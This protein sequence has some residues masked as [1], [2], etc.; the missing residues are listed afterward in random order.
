MT[1][2]D[3]RETYPYFCRVAA[4][5]EQASPLFMGKNLERLRAAKPDYAFA[6]KLC[7]DAFDLCSSSEE[8]WLRAA[9]TLV[10]FSMEF[11]H[12]QRQ[13][14]ETGR[15]LYSTF[16]EVEQH[17]YNDPARALSGPPYLWAMYFTQAFWI[18]HAKVWQFFLRDFASAPGR[19][20]VVLEVPSGNGLF[21]THF[22]RSNPRWRGVGVD[23]SDGSI[24]F[25]RRMTALN[26]L[27]EVVDVRKQDFFHLDESQRFERIICGEFLEHVED[28]PSVLRK[29]R[30]LLTKNGRLFLTAAV[31]AAN[32]DHIY[33][34]RS[35]AEVRRQV[36]DAGLAI[37]RELVQNVLPERDPEEPR[38]PVNYS[39][40]LR[41]A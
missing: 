27:R 18:T 33:L 7:R 32:I 5:L 36:T 37:E 26:G 16:Q 10:D 1:F 21:L 30:A 3:L 12:L 9:D 41:R 35:A 28:P 39:A 11:V 4:H 17:V 20:G 23:L 24:E 29:L 2:L 34:Y 14:D 31:W 22:L 8:E 25:T 19:P 38:T 15:Y 6:E 13:L 40:I